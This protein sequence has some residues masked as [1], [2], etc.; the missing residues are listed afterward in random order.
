MEAERERC[1]QWL[2]NY[3]RGRGYGVQLTE[4]EHLASLRNGG[5]VDAALD[6]WMGALA[7]HGVKAARNQTLSPPHADDS[8]KGQ[9]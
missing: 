2:L 8:Q 4:A 9:A 5:H 1:E 6:I 3:W 7:T